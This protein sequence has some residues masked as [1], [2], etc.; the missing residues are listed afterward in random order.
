MA[1]RLGYNNKPDD[2]EVA[3][4]NWPTLEEYNTSRLD[5]LKGAAKAMLEHDETCSNCRC[6]VN[7]DN[8]PFDIVC[9]SKYIIIKIYPA[10]L[11]NRLYLQ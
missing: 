7:K 9:P 3:G 8:Q 2:V 4:R 6:S 10:L 11:N 1:F 5:I